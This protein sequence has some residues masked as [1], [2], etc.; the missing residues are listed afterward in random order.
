MS[1]IR[2][3]VLLI[4]LI[5]LGGLVSLYP[6]VG[7]AHAEYERS[8]PPADAV[9]AQTPPEVQVWFTQELFRREGANALA[10]FGPAG[11]Q[12][13][14]GDARIDDDDR[15][16]MIVS[17]PTGLPDGRYTVTWQTLS[18]ED[19]DSH[20]GEFTFT[21]DASASGTSATSPAQTSVATATP[22]P[23][24]TLPPASTA[25]SPPQS[26]L[27]CLGGLV[28]GVLMAAAAPRWRK[29]END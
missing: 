27:P 22:A 23:S 20:S 19:G 24:P 3:A 17:L 9:I 8:D 28:L 12:V 4:S 11:G 10:V 5:T 2:L 18:L 14:N 6:A 21:V 29:R 15:T 1:R 26:N 16:H 7:H 13:D 25:T